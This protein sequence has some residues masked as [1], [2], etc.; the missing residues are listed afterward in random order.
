MQIIT[1]DRKRVG[2]ILINRRRHDILTSL[3]ISRAEPDDSGQY[4]CDPASPY[5]QS[6]RVHVTRGQYFQTNRENNSEEARN[7]TVGDKYG[8][9][10]GTALHNRIRLPCN[11]GVRTFLIKE[12]HGGREVTLKCTN[13]TSCIGGTDGTSATNCTTCTIND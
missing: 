7:L 4:A 8:S 3:I 1:H 12:E 2:T 10:T 13:S 6:V 5:A 9:D 11:N